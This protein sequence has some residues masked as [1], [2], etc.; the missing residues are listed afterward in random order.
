MTL[1]Q[2]ILQR[3]KLMADNISR[4]IRWL[5][6]TIS[7]IWR[8]HT[9]QT[10]FLASFWVTTCLWNLKNSRK[11][12]KSEQN[13]DISLLRLMESWF[14]LFNEKMHTFY[15]LSRP[16]QLWNIIS[17]FL[18]TCPSEQIHQAGPKE[19]HLYCDDF[20]ICIFT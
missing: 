18:L 10:A 12:L 3:N 8:Q 14:Y 1:L 5:M 2:P 9:W 19:C 6:K 17:A 15:L 16:L 13:E 7:S 4:N 11:E 20:A